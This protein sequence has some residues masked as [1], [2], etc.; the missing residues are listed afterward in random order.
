MKS[1]AVNQTGNLV[2]EQGGVSGLAVRLIELL[3]KMV[4]RVPDHLNPFPGEVSGEP[5]QIQSR[6]IHRRLADHSV[7]TFLPGDQLELKQLLVFLIQTFDSDGFRF[8][9]SCL[10]I[11]MGSFASGCSKAAA[12]PGRFKG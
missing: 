3:Q 7:Q 6:P 9:F 11:Q 8:H 10:Q 2:A 5:G 1:P 4:L 12:P